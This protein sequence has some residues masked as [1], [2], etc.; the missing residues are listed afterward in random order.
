M[1]EEF[2]PEAEQAVHN[3]TATN[4]TYTIHA[5][6]VRNFGRVYATNNDIDWSYAV[7]SDN[8]YYPSV[9]VIDLDGGEH[10]I[11]AAGLKVKI[12]DNEV[13]L[14]N[15]KDE[16]IHLCGAETSETRL[17]DI[18]NKVKEL[19]ETDP[20]ARLVKSKIIE[21]FAEGGVQIEKI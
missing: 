8:V 18:K 7:T 13:Y 1:F 10:R 12:E 15:E 20:I 21:V 3:H 11:S 17:Q 6:T 14:A 9:K 19:P 5:D 16:A 2:S 4:N